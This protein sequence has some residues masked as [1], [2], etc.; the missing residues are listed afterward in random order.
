[1]A[2]PPMLDLSE[3]QQF[4]AKQQTETTQ[5]ESTHEKSSNTTNQ[6]PS[7][8][9]KSKVKYAIVLWD[10][11]GKVE[12]DELPVKSKE[13]VTVS[14]TFGYEEADTDWWKVRNSA[15]QEGFVPSNY[16]EA[17]DESGRKTATLSVCTILQFIY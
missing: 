10:F 1:M 8:A 12:E 15:G 14:Q 11:P 3:V 5:Q 17:V 2:P 7:Q 16:L 13:L 9:E 4:F 6:Q